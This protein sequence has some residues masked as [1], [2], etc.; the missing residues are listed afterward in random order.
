MQIV[1]QY[2]TGLN[3]LCPHFLKIIHDKAKLLPV[4]LGDDTRDFVGAKQQINP[5]ETAAIKL[6][7]ADDL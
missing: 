1:Q 6:K 3:D 2:A 4:L 5:G 7:T